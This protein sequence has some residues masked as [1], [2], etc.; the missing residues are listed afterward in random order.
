MKFVPITYNLNSPDTELR[1]DPSQVV[2]GRTL[3]GVTSTQT[4]VNEYWPPDTANWILGRL[5][6]ATVTSVTP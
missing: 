4:T 3:S 2:I 6:K 5:K 1:G